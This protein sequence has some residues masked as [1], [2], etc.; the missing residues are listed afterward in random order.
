MRWFFIIFIEYNNAR[1]TELRLSPSQLSEQLASRNIVIPGGSI[2]LA[3]E[4]ISLE[5]TGNFESVAEIA[6]TIVQIPGSDRVLY[7]DE[8]ATVS[9]GYVDPVKTKLKINERNQKYPT[10]SCAS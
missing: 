1:L 8:I 5:P 9:R 4:K 2:D 7:L 6:K 10:N 3:N